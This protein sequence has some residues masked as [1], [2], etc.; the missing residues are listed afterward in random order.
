MNKSKT[1]KKLLEIL[2]FGYGVLIFAVIIN[3][4]GK[5]LGQKSWYDV[6]GPI[7]F[8]DLNLFNM[9]WLIVIYPFLLGASVYILNK[10]KARIIYGK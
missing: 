6:F 5:Y 9:F 10:Y 4:L 2:Y 3:L 8:L 7:N 1:M